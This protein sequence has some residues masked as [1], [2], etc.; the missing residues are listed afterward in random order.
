LRAAAH[1]RFQAQLEDL[2]YQRRTYGC[3]YY[4]YANGQMVTREDLAR[5]KELVDAALVRSITASR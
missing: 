5:I 4:Y 2:R 3:E 1:A